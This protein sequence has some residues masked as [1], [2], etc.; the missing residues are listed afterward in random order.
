M[1]SLLG[2]RL[3][4]SRA[5]KHDGHLLEPDAREE[6]TSRGEQAHR[7]ACG[8]LLW[9]Y[10]VDERAKEHVDSEYHEGSAKIRVDEHSKGVSVVLV[11]YE[12]PGKSA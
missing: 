11:A 1:Q 8:V 12:E 7:L 3:W 9:Q 2:S 10:V 5:V 4:I 6:V